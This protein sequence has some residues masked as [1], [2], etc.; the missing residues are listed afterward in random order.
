MKKYILFDLDGT[1]TDPE[2]GITRSVAYSLEHF[3]IH[4]ND[5]TSLR[6]F[7]GPPLMDSYIDFYG[8]SRENALKAIEKYRERFSCTGI[9][10][11]RIYD[12]IPQLLS[13]LVNKGFTLAIA[14]SKPE[15]Y[16]KQI[17][18]HFEI[19][20]YFS[21][22][23]GSE[24]DG[25]RA[26]K[27]DVIAYALNSFAIPASPRAIMIGDRKH[28]IIGAGKIG[29]ASIGVLYGFGSETELRAAGA[30][31]IAPTVDNLSDI[32]DSMF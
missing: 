28:D 25:R 23:C 19:A 18:E 4:V 8:F 2:L 1:L 9:F 15:I 14:S 17:A 16:V 7:I 12:G 21:A 13:S 31:H 10:E 24:L 11:N 27:A 3:N 6:R 32:I 26:D 5:L 30:Q 29:L 22:I 20:K